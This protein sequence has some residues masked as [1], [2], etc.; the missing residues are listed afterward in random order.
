M[1][2]ALMLVI[3]LHTG[4]EHPSGDRWFA[5][6]KAKHF[7]LAAFVQSASY[8]TLRSV[9]AGNSLAL[10]GASFATAGVSVAKELDD[11]RR[12][13]IVSS[14]DLVWDVAGMAA[15]SVLLRRTGGG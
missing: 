14:K 10:V 13:S 15:A 9:G 6:D 1:I 3:R 2:G 5:A 7:F 11:R 12:G 4:Q 8:S